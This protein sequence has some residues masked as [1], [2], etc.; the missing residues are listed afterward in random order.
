VAAPLSLSLAQAR[1]LALAAQGFTD[2]RPRGRVDR[3]HLRRVFDRVG[4]IQIDSVNVLVRSQELP[5]FARLGPHPRDLL[6]KAAA[7]GEVFEYWGHEASHIPVAQ[8]HLFR[9]KMARAAEHAW[10]GVAR[11]SRERPGYVEAVYEMVAERGPVVAGELSERTAP[12]G[13]WWDWDHAK[14]ALEWLFY[15][16]RIT[17][18]RRVNDFARLYDLPERM[19]PASALAV[20]TPV[21]ADARKALLLIAARAQGVSTI[22]DLTQYHRQHLARCRPLVAELVEAGDLVPA[23]VEGWK[24][25]AYVHPEATLP[26]RVRATALLSPFDSLIWERPR[27]ERLFGFHYRIEIY[28]PA[29]KRRFGYYVLPFLLGD[30]LVGRVDL[31]AERAIS[32]LLVRGA[33]TEPGVD[34]GPVAEAL[35]GE[36][37]LMAEWLGLEQVVVE[38]RGELAPALKA[39]LDVGPDR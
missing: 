38:G 1:R 16:G 34:E 26:R 20:P 7:D 30:E 15:T 35:A 29:P 5:L 24:E 36:L 39:A 27:V 31:K 2:P 11:M 18:R 37:A 33:Y 6:P 19:L 12:K 9:W 14:L 32:T 21:E 17:A 10:R 3:R 8:H 25:P 23:V 13:A 4:L 22:R 28:T